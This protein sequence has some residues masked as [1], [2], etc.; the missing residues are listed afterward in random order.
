MEQWDINPVHISC[1]QRQLRVIKPKDNNKRGDG[2]C[3]QQQICRLDT[4]VLI[5]ALGRQNV[6]NTY[7]KQVSWRLLWREDI[8]AGAKGRS[9]SDNGVLSEMPAE[10]ISGVRVVFY[11]PAQEIC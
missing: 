4:Q 11:K 8:R 10:V 2:I 9:T 5:S 3:L 7:G 6:S 1:W